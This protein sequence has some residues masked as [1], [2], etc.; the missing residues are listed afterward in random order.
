MRKT[1]FLA[2]LLASAGIALAAGARSE[3]HKEARR[4]D[5][6]RVDVTIHAG[7]DRIAIEKA[8][9]GLTASLDASFNSDD[10]VSADFRVRRSGSEA[11]VTIDLGESGD[12]GDEDAP[13]S[14]SRTKSGDCWY[15]GVS[16]DIPS[17]INASAGIGSA[18]F[19]LTGL[20]LEEFRL[21]SGA[22]STIVRFGEPNRSEL[23]TFK[24]ETGVGKFRGE[25]LG[26]GNVSD[27][28]IEGGVG[29]CA[30]DFSGAGRAYTRGKISLGVGSVSISIPPAVGVHVRCKDSWLTSCTAIGFT[31]KGSEEYVTENFD[32]APQRIELSIDV[33]VGKV[34]LVRQ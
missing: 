30:I 26:N 3:Y 5:E 11:M 19:D 23:R 15:V 24:V 29:N 8:D 1:I 22:S 12:E 16:P 34:K 13:H 32:S 10:D 9:S 6:A 18:H 28:V 21:S 27:F 4:A 33:G 20:Q 25:H 14:S 7:L 2:S 31:Q 17:T